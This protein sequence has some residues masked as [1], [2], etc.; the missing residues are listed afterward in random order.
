MP[1]T[2]LAI[3]LLVSWLVVGVYF[4]SGGIIKLE[5]DNHLKKLIG[6]IDTIAI[7]YK[8][9]RFKNKLSMLSRIE[10]DELEQIYPWTNSVPSFLSYLITACSFSLIGSI[11]GMIYSVVLQGKTIHDLK[12]ISNPLL[13]LLTGILVL[14]V[15]VIV[16][17][18]FLTESADI[19]PTSLMF[20]CLF[21]GLFMERFFNGVSKGFNKI[22]KGDEV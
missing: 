4:G 18:L 8:G 16:P 6:N 5:N 11:T 9:I 19:R 22:I 17:S 20:I 1:K 10:S 13:G 3:T 15:S 12:Y 14:G 2:I 7:E 21:C